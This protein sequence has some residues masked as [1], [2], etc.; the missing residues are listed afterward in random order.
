MVASAIDRAVTRVIF[1]F[2]FLNK[3]IDQNDMY[4]SI[5]H[6]EMRL[7]DT[8]TDEFICTKKKGEDGIVMPVRAHECEIE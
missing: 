5:L 7:R 2:F 1:F 8:I 3:K 6:P 4:I